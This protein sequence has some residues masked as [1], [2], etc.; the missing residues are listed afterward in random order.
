VSENEMKKMKRDDNTNEEKKS[1]TRLKKSASQRI[2]IA[3]KIL[4][5][6]IFDMIANFFNVI[7]NNDKKNDWIANVDLT[8]EIVKKNDNEARS[9]EKPTKIFFWFFFLNQRQH[10][11]KKEN[12]ENCFSI[13]L[14]FFESQNLEKEKTTK[15]IFRFFFFFK[16]ATN[17]NDIM[18]MIFVS[19]NKRDDMK[20]FFV[21]LI[22]SSF[23]DVVYFAFFFEFFNR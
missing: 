9:K 8:N 7:E 1:W 11:R 2:S 4:F 23:V 18:T 21:I 17:D 20:S 15:I 5:I 12:N 3:F 6:K 10:H 19:I 22:Q 16:R 14:F 13:F